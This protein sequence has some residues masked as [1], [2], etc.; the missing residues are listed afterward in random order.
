MDNTNN[1]RFGLGVF[2]CIFNK[3]FSKI[4]LLKRNKEKREKWGADWGNIGGVL[5]FGEKSNEACIREAKEEIGVELKDE[6]LKLLEIV[7]MPN[8]TENVHG[9]KFIY[10]TTIDENEKIT[11][12]P[13]SDEYH[14]FNL[15]NLLNNA[16]DSKEELNRFAMLAKEKFK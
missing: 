3:D 1:K 6:N 16:L 11:I 4:L 15:N 9:F 12:N 14:W 10:A 5:E 8:F 2:V 13:E 7:E